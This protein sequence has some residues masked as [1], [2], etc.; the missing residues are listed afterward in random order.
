MRGVRRYA[1]GLHPRIADAA[2]HDAARQFPETCPVTR[3]TAVILD[4][5][6]GGVYPLPRDPGI[7]HGHADPLGPGLRHAL[8]LAAIASAVCETL[9]H[10]VLGHAVAPVPPNP[11]A[12][13]RVKSGSNLWRHY[14]ADLLKRVRLVHVVEDQA[15]DKYPRPEPRS[16]GG[17]YVGAVEGFLDPS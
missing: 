12:L 13:V 16:S 5:F 1:R 3:G 14:L 6:P 4:G 15:T 2:T 8:A 17:G 7:R 10:L 9:R 11:V